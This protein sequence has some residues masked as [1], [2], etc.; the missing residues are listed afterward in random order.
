[1][2]NSLNYCPLKYARWCVISGAEKNKCEMMMMA[3]KAR[4]LQPTL[5]CVLGS[6]V[7]NCMK[8]IQ[9]GDADMM[10]L[11]AGDVYLAGRYVTLF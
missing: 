1:M 9:D 4:D 10:A 11:D 5:D 3:F 7:Q 6:N 8:M 2:I